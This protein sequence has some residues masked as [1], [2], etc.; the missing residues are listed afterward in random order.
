MF[1][2]RFAKQ[3]E[4]QTSV[5]HVPDGMRLYAIGDLHGQRDLL[6]RLMAVIEA[7]NAAR[8][9]ASVQMIFLG[10]FIDRGAHSA[11]LVKIFAKA[12][13]LDNLVFLR[14][15]HEQILIDVL[16]GDIDAAMLWPKIGGIATLESFG[17]DVNAQDLTD[18][19]E[20]I[21]CA[22]SAIP[23]RV[24]TWLKELPFSHAVGNYYFVH[25]GIRPGK[26]LSSQDPYDQLWIRKEFTQSKRRHG[27]IVVHGHTVNAQGAI[28]SPNRVAIDT[29]AYKTGRL[30]AVMLEGNAQVI[31]EVHA[32]ELIS[33]RA[34]EGVANKTSA[35][36]GSASNPDGP[37]SDSKTV[38]PPDPSLPTKTDKTDATAAVKSRLAGASI[39]SIISAAATQLST[40]AIF[41]ILARLLQPSDFGMVAFAAIFID[42]SR[43]VVLGGIPEALIQRTRWEDD[44][45]LTAFWINVFSALGFVV[46]I[47]GMCLAA[48]AWGLGQLTALVVIALSG[49]LVVDA[50]RAVQEARLRRDFAYRALAARTVGATVLGGAIGVACALAGLGV[51]ALVINRL[52]VSVFQT[53]IIW[54]A[55]PFVPRLRMV[56]AEVRPLMAYGTHVLTSRLVGQMNGRLPEFIIGLTAGAAALGMY[57]VGSRSL[58]FLVQTLINPIQ[59]TAL[60]AFSR[61][62]SKDAAGRAYSRFTQLCGA[63]TFPAF[64]GAAVI[65]EDFIDVFFGE[66]WHASALIMTILA[67]AV[68]SSTLLQ[69]FQPAMQGIGRPKAGISTELVKLASGAVIVGGLSFFGAAAAAAGDTIRRY[70]TLPE[71]FRMLKRELGLTS[72]R[73][74]KG[75]S[76]PLLCAIAMAGV[77]LIG[78]LTVLADFSP[79]LR[80]A[81]LLATG[82]ILYPVTMLVFAR[83]FLR[84]ILQSVESAFPPFLTKR[85][86]WLVGPGKTR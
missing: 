66:K 51:W 45:A 68:V 32:P 85:I 62:E 24:Q 52:A 15:N 31:L 67:F 19:H 23:E 71:S 77:L 50:L 49:S 38:S 74:I 34:Q 79:P 10:D 37:V 81:V 1:F 16:E 59:S 64:L 7:D 17:V 30:S 86:R 21:A 22:R 26:K 70:V 69:F 72:D 43:S 46:L 57:R 76:P 73:L 61:L 47:S 53:A 8:S 3:R 28:V 41:V 12:A 5:H 40:F 82:A 2:A 9:S 44:V 6:T 58:N 83:G 42:L 84:D 13:P 4:K 20:M 55:V 11:D 33:R 18:P 35:S 14:G 80:L 29:G 78:K 48:L 56:R 65:S 75:I 54:N 39:W 60:S 63:F 25:A 36:T 27:A